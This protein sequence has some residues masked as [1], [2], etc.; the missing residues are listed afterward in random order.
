MNTL[1]LPTI[2]QVQKTSGAMNLLAVEVGSGMQSAAEQSALL[3]DGF[4][5]GQHVLLEGDPGIGKTQGAENLANA[6]EFSVNERGYKRIQGVPDRLPAELLGSE[7]FDQRTGDYRLRLGPIFGNIVTVDEI[8]RFSTKTQAALTQALAEGKVTIGDHP[9]LVLPE[10]HFVVGTQNIHEFGQG[11]SNQ[12]NALVDRFGASMRL[13]SPSQTDRENASKAFAEGRI[14]NP[15]KIGRYSDMAFFRGIV[16]AVP[17]DESAHRLSSKILTEIGQQSG[18]E[19]LADGYRSVQSAI[20]MAQA[21]TVRE[22]ATTGAVVVSADQMR[23]VLPSVLRHRFTIDSADQ[24]AEKRAVMSA[25]LR[26]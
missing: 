2:D 10:G 22:S 7:V 4:F 15:R 20:R 21:R 11:T 14:P 3:V 9:T 26:V 6:M 17:V 13:A 24:E 5:A 16:R 23:A 8:N 1:Q 19:M 18:V 25:L 12:A